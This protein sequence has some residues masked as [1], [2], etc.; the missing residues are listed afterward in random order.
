MA[1]EKTKEKTEDK[2]EKQ[3]AKPEKK[4]SPLMLIIII[5][6]AGLTIGGGGAVSFLMFKGKG[7]EKDKAGHEK[8]EEKKKD[9]D[10]HGKKEGAGDAHGNMKSLEPSFIVN[11]AGGGHN[12]MKVDIS[13]ELTDKAVESEIDSKLPKIKDTILMILSEQTPESIA[14]NKGKLRLKDELLKRLNSFLTAGKIE[15]VYFT[16][17]VVQ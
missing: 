15:N 7:K 6:I 17:F 8:V 2:A 5:V 14:D 1:E 13:L 4:K 9:A 16:S 11:L 12:F 3:E 10:K